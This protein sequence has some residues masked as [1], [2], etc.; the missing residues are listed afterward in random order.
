MTQAQDKTSLK[1]QEVQLRR[2]I[3]SFCAADRLTRD[4]VHERRS[5][6]C[7]PRP[8]DDGVAASSGAGAEPRHRQ[9]RP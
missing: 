7:E 6:V 8:A 5:D 3:R 1:R 2:A 4:A 9:R